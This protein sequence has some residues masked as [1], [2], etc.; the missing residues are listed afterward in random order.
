[1]VVV[2]EAA[3]EEVYAGVLTALLLAVVPAVWWTALVQLVV[4]RGSPVGGQ[5]WV[6]GFA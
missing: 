1:L 5:Q 3:F 4:L 6:V 2:S